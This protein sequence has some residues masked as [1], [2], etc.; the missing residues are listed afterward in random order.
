MWKRKLFSFDQA[1]HFI[2]L[3]R[4]NSRRRNEQQ[5]LIIT[6]SDE[7]NKDIAALFSIE[8]ISDRNIRMFLD[9]HYETNNFFVCSSNI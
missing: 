6:I 8:L 3:Q 7:L 2:A 1:V 9:D 5:P 4:I